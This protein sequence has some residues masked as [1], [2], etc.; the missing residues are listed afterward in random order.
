M[1][2]E[3]ERLVREALERHA[4]HDDVVRRALRALDGGLAQEPEGRTVEVRIAVCT[5]TK[6]EYRAVGDDAY[7]CSIDATEWA[8]DGPLPYRLS[9]VTASVPLPADPTEIR[10]EVQDG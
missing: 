1:R 4:G 7:D 10:G 3:T 8:E 9:W 6:G 2:Q 5:N